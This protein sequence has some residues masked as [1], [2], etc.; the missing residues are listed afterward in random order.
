[1]IYGKYQDLRD[2]A[3]R[4]LLEYNINKLP[5]NVL[6]ITRSSG[7]HVIKN[8]SVQKLNYRESGISI[9]DG[10]M[11][12]IIYNDSE[13]VER[14][15]FTISHELG[16]IFLGH[17]LKVGYHA[18]TIATDKPE[19]EMQAD[20]FAS[21]LLCPACVLWGL[22]LHTPEEIS[23]ICKVSYQAAKIRADRMKILYDRNKFLTSPLEREVYKMFFDYI[24]N[25]RV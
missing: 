15:R 25:N 20:M 1:M 13:S 16:H 11:W 21:R 6:Q 3:W 9:F 24:K 8:S 2:A 7:I 12:Y 18:R 5:V 4:C 22:D 19:T 10:K 14:S 17:P 23:K